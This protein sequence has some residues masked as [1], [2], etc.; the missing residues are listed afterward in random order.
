M[1]DMRTNHP[2]ESP[3]LEPWRRYGQHMVLY[4]V[5]LC[6]GGTTVFSLQ[7]ACDLFMQWRP[8]DLPD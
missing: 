3:S 7:E 6:P 4:A 2:N 5:T 8:T 1:S